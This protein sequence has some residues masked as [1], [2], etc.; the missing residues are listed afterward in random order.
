MFH[1]EFKCKEC[2]ANVCIE[3]TTRKVCPFCGNEEKE[4]TA[5]LGKMKLPENVKGEKKKEK[6]FLKFISKILDI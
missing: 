5:R 2:G 3:G 4:D 1:V 6:H